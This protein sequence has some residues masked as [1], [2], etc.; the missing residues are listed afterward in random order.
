MKLVHVFMTI[1]FFL[2]LAGCNRIFDPLSTP[3]QEGKI[4]FTSIKN[5]TRHIFMIN[6]DGSGLTQLT[7]GKSSSY[8]PTWSPNGDRIAFVLATLG[9]V[10]G[11]PIFLMNADGSNLQLLPIDPG[12][13]WPLYFGSAPDWSPD[14]EKIAYQHELGP[15]TGKFGIFVADL[16]NEKLQQLAADYANFSITYGSPAWSPDGSKI[17]FLSNQD[18]APNDFLR[19]EIYVTNADGSNIQKLTDVGFVYEFAWNPNGKRIAFVTNKG[20]YII[21]ADGSN[22]QWLTEGRSPIWNHDGTRIAFQLSWE[23]YVIDLRSKEVRKILVRRQ[24]LQFNPRAWSPD[25]QELLILSRSEDG[26][27]TYLDMVNIKTGE[28]RRLLPDDSIR[29]VEWF[30][31]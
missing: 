18:Y 2:L 12:P 1:S 30:Q 22:Q 11:F 5:G 6:P 15:E 17:A 8:D 21:A 31:K 25:E 19:R 4:L 28:L 13:G 23:L 20:I 7:M 24:G 10:N 16:I 26:Q 29:S 14:G 3:R 27:R 9:S